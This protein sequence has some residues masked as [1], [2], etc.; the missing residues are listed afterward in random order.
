MLPL[1]K[2]GDTW[3]HII[4]YRMFIKRGL[5]ENLIKHT[6]SAGNK[7]LLSTGIV[8]GMDH[9]H[10]LVW[11]AYFR[12]CFELLC[13]GLGSLF[14]QLCLVYLNRVVTIGKKR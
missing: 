8:R 13:V 9:R 7:R 10:Q 6:N 11:F 1:P 5:G 4:A 12:E 3:K 2:P 14:W